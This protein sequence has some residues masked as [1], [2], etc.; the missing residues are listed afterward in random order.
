MI[1]ARY[2]SF[3]AGK[4]DMRHVFT[5]QELTL[6]IKD[7][8]EGEFPFVWLKG[9]I[10]NLN[11]AG[12]GHVYFTLKDGDAAIQC[13]WFKGSHRHHLGTRPESLSTGLDVLCAGRIAVYPPRGTYQL[14]AEVVQDQGVG[15]LHL[16]FEALKKKLADQ[17]WF[18]Q[19]RKR[20]LPESIN[21]LAVITAP[22]GAAI[23]DF[24]RLS[25]DRGWGGSIRI[26][27]SLV[28]GEGAKETIASA[29]EQ[30]NLENWADL[31]VLIRGGGSLEDLWSFNTEEVAGAV[32]RSSVPVLTG[33]GH[34]ID[35]TIADLVA[36][37]QAATPSHAAQ[38]IWPERQALTQKI[39]ELDMAM[40]A[41]WSRLIRHK[42]QPLG[43]CER[44]LSWLSP[45]RHLDRLGQE[46]KR[47]A[48]TL[49][50][51][52]ESGL[53]RNEELL[54]ALTERLRAVH[55]PRRWA[56][57]ESRSDQLRS[58]LLKAMT[59]FLDLLEQRLSMTE[60]SLRGADPLRPLTRGYSLVT[61]GP[62]RS[63]LRRASQVSAG[64][65][66]EIL[67][68]QD[69]IRAEV[70]DVAEQGSPLKNWIADH[71]TQ[72]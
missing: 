43:Q 47:M 56:L 24:L 67:T 16:E 38:M 18:D 42:E 17:G 7:V 66:V 46:L 69:R 68:S 28:Q 36:D 34:Q 39:D 45:Q 40:A 60:N 59:R 4:A 64:D 61:V 25:A 48:R 29:L 33:I 1:I 22:S 53:T 8:L 15:R 41:A 20:P 52:A 37:V 3:A 32:Y 49:V 19:D 27:P 65:D 5:V 63:I 44:A 10:G 31:A 50:A 30:V 23:M 21:R 70:V 13:V 11:Q 55:G 12:S 51:S 14:I 6:A 58:G 26:Y 62:D 72:E 54:S 35:Q 71:G 2:V 9:Q 57:E